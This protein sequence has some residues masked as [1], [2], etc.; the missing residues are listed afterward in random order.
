M[1]CTTLHVRIDIGGG[2]IVPASITNEAIADLA[3]DK[4]RRAYAV[5]KASDGR[6][7]LTGTW[8]AIPR[9]RPELYT[10]IGALML[11]SAK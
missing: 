3:L 8:A 10:A 6:H 11:A 2:A 5:I 7:R 4:G 9:P 1:A